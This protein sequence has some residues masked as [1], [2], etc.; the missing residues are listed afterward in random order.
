MIVT[1]TSAARNTLATLESRPSGLPAADPPLARTMP[2]QPLAS[3]V[4]Q[5]VSATSPTATSPVA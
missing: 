4:A 1:G 2:V 3:A 5:I